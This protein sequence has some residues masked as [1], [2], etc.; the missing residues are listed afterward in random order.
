[1][2]YHH[3]TIPHIPLM[4]PTPLAMLPPLKPIQMLAPSIDCQWEEF[5]VEVKLSNDNFKD[6][7][8]K[9]MQG[10]SEQMSYLVK[11]Q[12][13]N[14]VMVHHKFGVHMSRLWCTHRKQPNHIVQFCPILLQ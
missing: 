9:T 4:Q 8:M 5:K 11:N 2:D 14:V 13:Q 10:I 6:E 3:A 7:M 1:V 12:N